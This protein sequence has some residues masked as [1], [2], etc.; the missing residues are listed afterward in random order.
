MSLTGVPCLDRS[1]DC[2]VW[3]ASGRCKTDTWVNDNCLISCGRFDICT[4][5]VP[6]LQPIGTFLS[7]W[8]RRMRFL[9]NLH[10]SKLT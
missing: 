6:T 4:C 7:T 8:Q 2:K 3:A 9:A 10:K 1:S 5:V